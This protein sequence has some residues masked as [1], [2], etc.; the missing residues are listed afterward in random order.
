ME[1]KSLNLKAG[2]SLIV[3][4][5]TII[6]IIILAA[7]IIL[8]LKNN[9][10]IENAKEAAFI[11]DMASFHDELEMYKAA[12]YAKTSGVFEPSTLN[13]TTPAGVI[14]LIPSIEGKTKYINDVEVK[15]GKLYYVGVDSK[16]EEWATKVDMVKPSYSGNAPVLATGMTPIKWDDSGNLVV[17][18]ASDNTWYDYKNKKWANARTA[19]GSMWV[20]IPRYEYDIPTLN[21][22]TNVAG[23]INVNFL[24]GISTTSTSG[25]IVHPAF[26]FGTLELPGIW[27]AKFEAGGTTSSVGSKPGAVSLR[28][29]ILNT[30]FNACINMSTINGTQYGW[31]TTGTGIDTHLIKNVEW[32]AMAY[33]SHSNYGINTEIANNT[34]T[35]TYYTGGG[36]VDS[37][38]TNILQSTTGNVYGIYDTVGGVY[39]I[40]A[41]YVNNGDSILS[42]NAPSLLA[43]AS[44]YKDVYLPGDGTALGIYEANKDKKGDAIYETSSTGEMAKAWYTDY[45]NMPSGMFA[46]FNRSGFGASAIG[47]I[48]AFSTNSGDPMNFVGFRPVLNVDSSL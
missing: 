30:M 32:G 47:G 37:Y 13:A 27:V 19:D 15:E 8:T 35:T 14:A 1:N 38:K 20:W 33:L 34:D 21:E 17:T 22:H 18:T 25:Y 29:V 4:V 31:G 40:S 16:K 2:I 26:T 46:F 12:Q 42:E 10:P 36:S 11:N 41:A 5:I 44:R 6:V 43:A 28:R 45:S 9:N 39:E 3:L 7:A 23:T 48:F 24:Q